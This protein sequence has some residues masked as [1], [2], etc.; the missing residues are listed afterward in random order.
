[1]KDLF[2]DS[3]VQRAIDRLR[4]FEP[5]EGYY[6]AFS[7]GKDSIALYRVTELSGVKFDAHMAM[8]TADPPPLVSF[9]KRHYPQVERHAPECG[10]SLAWQIRERGLPTRVVRWCCSEYK[11]VGGHGRF[12]ATGIRSAESR[13]RRLRGIVETCLRGGHRRFIHPLKDWTDADVWEFIKAQQ[14]PYPALYDRGWKRIGCILCPFQS[15]RERVRNEALWPVMFRIARESTDM[16][17]AKSESAQSRFASGQA[18]FDW[19]MAKDL[20]YPQKLDEQ[21]AE[22]VAMF[23]DTPED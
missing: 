3:P 7:G 9:V 23:G 16:Y 19:W 8:T 20:A 1:M 13:M 4:E 6:L 18:M 11:E 15:S 17:W 12:V 14:L 21:E 5:P 2:G 22:M 10:R